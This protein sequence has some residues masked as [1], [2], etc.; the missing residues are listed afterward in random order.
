MNV[1][2]FLRLTI[3]ATALPDKEGVGQAIQGSPYLD[4]C[5]TMDATQLFIYGARDDFFVMEVI[6]RWH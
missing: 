1:K 5:C 4:C 3:R 2:L 6:Y